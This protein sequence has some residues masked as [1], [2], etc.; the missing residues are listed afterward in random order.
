MS[1][2][3]TLPSSSSSSS[4]NQMQDDEKIPEKNGRLAFV[5]N[6]PLGIVK[7]EK[8]KLDVDAT[9]ARIKAVQ[10]AYLTNYDKGSCP[11]FKMVF[12]IN[13]PE[14]QKAK[15]DEFQK[16][17]NE[18]KSSGSLWPLANQIDIV[19]YPW[20]KLKNKGFPYGTVRNV[21]LHSSETQNAIGVFRQAGFYPY[22][23]IGDGD[24]GKRS[25]FINDQEVNIFKAIEDKLN[26]KLISPS[27]GNEGRMSNSA[28]SNSNSP[29]LQDK[30]SASASFLNDK[31]AAGLPDDSEGKDLSPSVS[32]GK[33]NEEVK[34]TSAHADSPSSNMSVTAEFVNSRGEVLSLDEDKEQLSRNIYLRPY[35]IAGGYR[36]KEEKEEQE[37]DEEESWQGKMARSIEE[38]MEIRTQLAK[39]VNPLGPYFPEPN[40]FIDGTIVSDVNFGDYGD[41][42]RKLGEE[43]A[44]FIQKDTLKTVGSKQEETD[45][46]TYLQTNT[47]PSRNRLVSTFFDLAIETEIDRLFKNAASGKDKQADEINPNSVAQHHQKSN[48][49]KAAYLKTR[50]SAA[51]NG[52]EIFTNLKNFLEKNINN[53]DRIIGFYHELINQLKETRPEYKEDL[54]YKAYLKDRKPD[55]EISS[56]AVNL[57]VAAGQI[58]SLDDKGKSNRTAQELATLTYTALDIFNTAIAKVFNGSIN[59]LL[60][61]HWKNELIRHSVAA[62]VSVAVIQNATLSSAANTSSSISQS[63]SSS[64]SID[65]TSANTF[66][67]ANKTF[68]TSAGR[69]NYRKYKQGQMQSVTALT[70]VS[71]V[72]TE[73]TTKEPSESYSEFI[74]KLGRR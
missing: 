14:N 7:K 53:I 33:A 15:L 28:N 11:P 46:S 39:T 72:V 12:C 54:V 61:A 74:F 5:V 49:A 24:T 57:M 6:I 65:S 68:E 66:I 30:M 23:A 34:Q 50:Y 9:I 59:G 29:K 44:S 37:G 58:N 3:G 62:P 13:C 18:D 47:H 40:L 36:P 21:L 71:N 25:V 2:S 48:L 67:L 52:G 10:E 60:Q 63:T 45:V 64:T 26:T 69:H 42:F 31:E 22:V 56:L 20:K 51:R 70:N 4:S 16:K 8:N 35:V 73:E 19:A 55:A 32:L 1:L 17:W 43:I 38:D 27:S 41:E